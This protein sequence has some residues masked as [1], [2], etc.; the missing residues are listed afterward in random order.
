MNVKSIRFIKLKK[1]IFLF[2]VT[3]LQNKKRKSELFEPVSP[4]VHIITY[5]NLHDKQKIIMDFK[6]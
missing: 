4:K 2:N 3:N 5:Y 1:N 6:P